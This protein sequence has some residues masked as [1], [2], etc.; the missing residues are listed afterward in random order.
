MTT[1]SRGP[2]CT[3]NVDTM[4]NRLQ[5]QQLQSRRDFLRNCANGIGAFALADLLASEG[6]TAPAADLSA[7]DAVGGPGAN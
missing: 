1:G 6:L 5:F 7:A 2:Q 3:I 4:M